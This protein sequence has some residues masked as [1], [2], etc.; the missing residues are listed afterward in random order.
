MVAHALWR[1][2]ALRVVPW[3]RPY[4]SC[5]ISDQVTTLRASDL[6]SVR[7]PFVIPL[8]SAITITW[9]PLPVEDLFKFVLILRR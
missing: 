3:P 5:G 1:L 7:Q 9:I 2:E 4:G 6:C 8:P